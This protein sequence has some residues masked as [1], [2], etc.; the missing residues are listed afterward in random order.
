MNCTIPLDES[1][2]DIALVAKDGSEH[3]G[4][5]AVLCSVSPLLHD[6]CTSEEDALFVDSSGSRVMRVVLQE[7]SGPA[8]ALL[9]KLLDAPPTPAGAAPPPTSAAA[10]SGSR[11]RKAASADGKGQQAPLTASLDELHDLL[12]LLQ[13]LGV[14][15]DGKA[16]ARAVICRVLELCPSAPAAGADAEPE[17]GAGDFEKAWHVLCMLVEMDLGGRAS[18]VMYDAFLRVV[19]YHEHAPKPPTS[20][21]YSPTS[22]RY[23]PRSPDYSPTTLVAAACG[24]TGAGGASGSAPAPQLDKL[25]KQQAQSRR[26]EAVLAALSD[27]ADAKLSPAVPMAAAFASAV[28]THRLGLGA[29]D[30]AGLCVDY[31]VVPGALVRLAD[32]LRAGCIT[33][34]QREELLSRLAG[35]KGEALSMR[36]VAALC[37]KLQFKRARADGGEGL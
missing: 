29:Y 35:M 33:G 28:N 10:A 23:S 34:E 37:W 5:R 25:L 12:K 26:H 15:G 31:A 24:P 17:P 21:L 2:K 14:R 3:K 30:E 16:G 6:I 36:E 18:D 32:L 7:G 9:M 1:M 11:K 20:P 13:Y 27:L 8:V 22:P 19:S 4:H